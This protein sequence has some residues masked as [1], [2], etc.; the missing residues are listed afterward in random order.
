MV[1]RYPSAYTDKVAVP[2]TL[3]QILLL[4]SSVSLIS[5][6]INVETQIFVNLFAELWKNLPVQTVA[7]SFT[8]KLIS[9]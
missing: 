9:R 7:T 4:K 8:F 2:Y 6:F 1:H 5:N 3:L